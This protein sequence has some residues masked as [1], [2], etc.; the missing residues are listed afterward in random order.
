MATHSPLDIL[1]QYW[2]Y[3]SFRPLQE[4]IVNSVLEGKDTLALL[5]TGGG[6]SICFQVPAMAK[7]GIC[8]VISPLIALMRDQVDNL[9]K[10]GIPAVALFTGM[11]YR[12]IDEAYQMA[13]DGKFKFLYLSPERLASEAFRARLP[14]LKISLIAVDEAHCIS[15]WGYDFRPQ[16]LRIAEIRALIPKVV[17]LALT[18]TATP[19]VVEDIQQRLEFSK[20]NVLQKSFERNNLSYS[21]LYDEDKMKKLIEVCRK[22][23]GVGIVYVSIRKRTEETSYLLEQNAISYDF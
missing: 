22:V 20:P 14:H 6:K 16:Y 17:L 1:E 3:N 2:K 7:D 9:L 10:K 11:N 13:I 15:Q 23:P 4:D 12:E 18:A 19:K 8:L 21:V 5:P